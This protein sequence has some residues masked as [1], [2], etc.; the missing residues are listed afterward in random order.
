MTHI[1]FVPWPLGPL[2]I[3]GLLVPPCNAYKLLPDH[4][5]TGLPLKRSGPVY[6]KWFKWKKKKLWTPEEFCGNIK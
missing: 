1:S 3:N 5:I 4:L 2:E 6:E